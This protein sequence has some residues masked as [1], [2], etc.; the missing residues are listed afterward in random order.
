LRGGHEWGNF[1]VA[2][3]IRGDVNRLDLRMDAMCDGITVG[4][5]SGPAVVLNGIVKRLGTV[6]DVMSQP[7]DIEEYGGLIG[8][9][10]LAG[11]YKLAVLAKVRL[12]PLLNLFHLPGRKSNPLIERQARISG[13]SHRKSTHEVV[14]FCWK[15]YSPGV[16][17]SA[18]GRTWDTGKIG[19]LKVEEMIG[20]LGCNQLRLSIP[21]F[22]SVRLRSEVFNCVKRNRRM[23]ESG[24]VCRQILYG[25]PIDHSMAVA[26]PGPDRL[27]SKYNKQRRGDGSTEGRSKV[28]RICRIIRNS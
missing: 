8:T 3:H 19:I 28:F 21:L 9:G 10:R 7:A 15:S 16:A 14:P 20:R 5:G 22:P 1:E 18:A 11:R 23:Q 6:R 25:E 24:H 27:G 17:A 26:S 13:L 4:I 2:L 12:E